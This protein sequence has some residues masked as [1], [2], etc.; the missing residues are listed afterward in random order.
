MKIKEANLFNTV[1]FCI[2]KTNGYIRN[3]SVIQLTDRVYNVTLYTLS[4]SWITY[5]IQWN[6]YMY[7]YM[8]YENIKT[9]AEINIT[10]HII[11]LKTYFISKY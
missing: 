5:S 3:I 4:D 2:K 10:I 7:M 1:G 11:I 6:D 8:N 9:I